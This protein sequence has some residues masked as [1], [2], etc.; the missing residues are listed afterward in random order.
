VVVENAAEVAASGRSVA[1]RGKV[2]VCRDKAGEVDMEL[3]SGDGVTA[4]DRVKHSADA[5]DASD[6]PASMSEP[7]GTDEGSSATT[8]TT[9]NEARSSPRKSARPKS[10]RPCKSGMSLLPLNQSTNG[11]SGD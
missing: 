7:A 5:S 11:T 6:Q 9:N 3:P 4:S 10:A 1:K 2:T 8:S